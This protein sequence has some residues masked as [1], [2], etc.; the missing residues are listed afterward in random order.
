MNLDLQLDVCGRDQR[1]DGHKILMDRL[2]ELF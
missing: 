1:G 2:G